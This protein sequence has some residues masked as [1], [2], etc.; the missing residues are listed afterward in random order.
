MG[1]WIAP[2]IKRG[3]VTKSYRPSDCARLIRHGV[4][5]NGL[6][7]LMP[8]Q[9]FTW[10]SDQEVSDIVLYLQSLPPVDR[11]MPESE[12]GAIYSMLIATRQIPI[13]AET[14]DHTAA[15]AK[16]PPALE[17]TT[18]LGKHLATTCVG[19]H[20]PRLAGGPIVGGDPA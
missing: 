3:G 8:S 6:P 13:A 12:L 7:A 20:G 18:E 11:V 10:L 19:C 16:T 5:P 9:D 4:K 14:L 1:K 2:N 15:R 17:P